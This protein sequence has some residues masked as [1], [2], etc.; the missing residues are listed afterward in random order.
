MSSK[1][2]S[3]GLPL[4]ILAELTHRCPL[5]CPYCSNPLKLEKPKSELS[6]E[7]WIDIMQQ[8]H[9]MGVLQIHFSGGEPAL[10]IDLEDLVK[11]ATNID[12]YSNLIT[13]GVNLSAERLHN[14]AN[15][16]LS[17]VQISI[18]DSEEKQSNK[19]GGHRNGHQ[20]KL[21]AAKTVRKIGLPLTINAPIHRMNIAHLES[22]INLAVKLGAARLEVV[23]VQYYGWAFYNR[24]SLM[25]KRSQVDWA[26]QVINKA[27]ED[28]L[29]VLEIDY[30]LPDYYASKPKSCMGGWG[31]QFLNVTP[32][33]KVLPCHAAESIT[34]LEFDNVMEKS[35]LEIWQHSKS[36]ELY[37]GI[38][39]M[40]E[41]CRRCER[42]KIDW[43]GC[44]CQA[45][46]ISGDASQMDPACKFSDHH[47][48]FVS[49]AEIDS[50]MEG[51][52]FDYRKIGA[53]E[54]IGINVVTNSR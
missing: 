21:E 38:D 42:H 43:G 11:G 30:V 19:I 15:L 3:I 24:A 14:L 23:H 16:G 1:D 25:P 34:D 31:R 10:R 50:S 6:T 51:V 54:N 36:F 26:T 37:R 47:E 2:K 27:R 7:K 48:H 18:Q 40:P 22:I 5:Q 20:L 45:F 12:L 41:T 39:W 46:A 35:L 9:D 17:H 32:S 28:L 52:P 49:L 44:R 4:A 8:A 13:S 33:G 53:F 29:G